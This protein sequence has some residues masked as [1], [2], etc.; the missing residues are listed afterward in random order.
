MGETVVVDVDGWDGESEGGDAT[1]TFTT[2]ATAGAE[3]PDELDGLD[4]MGSA[5]GTI[6]SGA[7]SPVLYGFL[8]DL[9]GPGWGTAAAAV[10]A[11]A[12]CPLA[13]LLAPR[14]RPG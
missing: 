1:F 13:V 7:V 10:V 2:K 3:V 12:V 4:A 5:E 6:G 11:V 9:A 14:L 8:G